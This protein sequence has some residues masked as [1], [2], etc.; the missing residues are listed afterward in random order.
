MALFQTEPKYITIW[1][2]F[3]PSINTVVYLPL[4]DDYKDEISWTT[5]TSTWT[6]SL[7]TEWGVKCTRLNWWQLYGL[8][9]AMITWSW[10]RT[11]NF[12]FKYYSISGSDWWTAVCRWSESNYSFYSLWDNWGYYYAFSW[13]SAS[14]D[15]ES[16]TTLSNWTWYNMVAIYNWSTISIYL[17]W[18][19]IWSKSVS[20][21]TWSSNLYIWWR[22]S[23]GCKVNW[24]INNVI[25]ENRART[26][27]EI[28]RYYNLTKSLY[29]IS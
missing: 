4:T 24:F 27:Q 6:V 3:L 2:S 23:W 8:S 9:S 20:L 28:Q 19:L 15:I 29:G 17:N 12:W 11:L 5:L 18:V 26:A 10:T 25:V 21:T 7:V 14:A 22:P 13:Y 1:Y 16:T